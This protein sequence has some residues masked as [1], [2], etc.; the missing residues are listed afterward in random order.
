MTLAV[1]PAYQSLPW[2]A[3]F[4]FD[5]AAENTQ[6]TKELLI[7]YDVGVYGISIASSSNIV[8]TFYAYTLEIINY[9]TG[10]SLM[11]EPV[12][13]LNVQSDCRLLYRLPSHWFLRKN[14]KIIVNLNIH[15]GSTTSDYW[16]NLLCYTT[17][18][19]PNPGR[20][21][22][23]YSFPRTIGFQ[24]N[25]GAVTTSQPFGMTPTGSIAKNALHDFE[26][27]ALTLDVS[28][29]AGLRTFPDFSF[30]FSLE[31][32]GKR[33]F[34]R[35][36]LNGLAGGGPLSQQGTPS[37]ALSISGFPNN[38]VLQYKLPRPELIPRGTLMRFDI[39]PA[40][41]YVSATLFKTV[42]VEQCC[43]AAIGSHI[44]G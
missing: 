15:D 36:V 21:P 23:I 12:Q 10:E 40:P 18:M 14:E 9:H 42:F 1:T 3:P 35:P 30:Q 25:A 5:N 2:T 20:S 24:D 16:V 28:G 17:K 7:P 38:Q 44:Y 29:D 4:F 8:S 33:F 34:D 41:T 27:T 13:N 43:F 22:F 11:D 6:N 19:H 37:A 39:F 32:N 26:M 31:C